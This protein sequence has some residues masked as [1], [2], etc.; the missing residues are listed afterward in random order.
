MSGFIQEVGA[1]NFKVDP[2]DDWNGYSDCENNCGS[3][4]ALIGMTKCPACK[5][6]KC[7]KC[8]EGKPD[9]LDLADIKV[10]LKKDYYLVPKNK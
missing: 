4:T 2:Q 10:I 7:F 9:G 5:K 1:P 8:F 3:D 6:S